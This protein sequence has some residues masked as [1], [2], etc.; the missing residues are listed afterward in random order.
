MVGKI[1]VLEGKH[2]LKAVE[3]LAAGLISR[4]TVVCTETTERDVKDRKVVIWY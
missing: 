1:V 3:L 2:D 4:I